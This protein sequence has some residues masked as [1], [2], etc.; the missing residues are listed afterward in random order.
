M[1]SNIGVGDPCYFRVNTDD[2]FYNVS[3]EITYRCN[4]ECQHCF[5]KSNDIAYLGLDR[6]N[7][8][9]LIDELAAVHV[10]NVYMTGGEPTKYPYFTDAVSAFNKHGIEVILATNGYDINQYMDFIEENVSSK[11]GV[12]I[13]IDGCADIHNTLRGRIDA[14]ERATNSIKMLV[15]RGIPVRVSSIIWDKNYEQLEEQIEYLYSIGVSQINLTIPV[16]VGRADTNDIILHKSYLETVNRVYKLQKKYTS[17][18]FHIFLKRQEMLNEQSLP[19]QGGQ[20]IMHIN[21]NGEIY[22]CSWVSKA[23]LKEYSKTW[24]PGNLQECINI[25]RSF[26]E[27]IVAREREYGCSGCP[28]MAQIYNGDKLAKDPLNDL[29]RG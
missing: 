16:Q 26:R 28:A 22:P 1:N 6:E 18:S 11:S 3:F 27:V 13:S 25:I 19:C 9:A 2:D 15:A 12:Y 10:K 5:N 20:K 23:G 7:V 29:L 21:S 17:D 14:F 4:L 24:K 8:L